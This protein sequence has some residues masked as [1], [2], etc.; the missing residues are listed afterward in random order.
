MATTIKK[1]QDEIEE[2]QLL[3]DDS[4]SDEMTKQLAKDEIASLKEQLKNMEMSDEDTDEDT[5]KPKGKRGRPKKDKSSVAVPKKKG[6]RGRPKKVV[7][8]KVVK[9]KKQVEPKE[10]GG[11]PDC[12]ELLKRWTERRAKAKTSNKKRKTKPV[13]RKIA[14]D[15]VDSVE[16]AIKNVPKTELKEKP[17]QILK[18]FDTLRA[19]AEQFLK[20]FR[21]VLG[22]DYK[23]SDAEKELKDL[24]VLIKGIQKK[25]S[26]KY[27]LGDM[28]E[29]RISSA[30]I[31]DYWQG[32]TINQQDHFLSDHSS[33]F[34]NSGSWLS[35]LGKPYENLPLDIQ[36]A[37][38]THLEEGRYGK[39]DMVDISEFNEGIVTDLY[40]K[41]N[42]KKIRT[43][44]QKS[45]KEAIESA[46]ENSK[47]YKGY[48]EVYI[49]AIF[50]GFSKNGHFKYSG[51]Y[52]GQ[53]Y[54]KGNTVKGGGIENSKEWKEYQVAS[55]N[56][57][58]FN[59]QNEFTMVDGKAVMN[60][61]TKMPE[62]KILNEKFKKSL[63]KVREMQKEGNNSYAKGDMVGGETSPRIYVAD[64]SAYNNGKL[65]GSWLDISDYSNGYEVMEA[66]GSLLEDWSEQ[67]GEVREEYAIHDFEGFPNELYSESMGEKEFDII[68]GGISI[69]EDKGVPMNVIVTIMKEY[70]LDADEVGDWFDEHYQGYFDNDEKF[71]DNYIDNIGGVEELGKDT[72]ATYFD[73]NSFGRD[74]AYDYSNYD[75]HYFSTYKKGGK[76]PKYNL[77]K[78]INK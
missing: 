20:A 67:S 1:I 73:Y 60:D 7:K 33:E 57:N 66:I 62:Y 3:L 36:M 2:Y 59:R 15:V 42:G 32:L 34:K 41:I 71:A 17:K 56:I 30:E 47:Y 51:R 61:V 69:S 11:E 76:V 55:N 10:D 68:I 70:S 6:K 54:A 29:G 28:V 19:S 50:V 72:L 48:A 52:K 74:L 24:E 21:G 5:D 65:I 23:T 16:K 40:D 13:F 58:R 44:N 31:R 77:T 4:S 37:I 64:L 38:Q 75:G 53:K 39:G 35:K 43:Q 22:D 25:Y 26:V 9:P 8:V 63:K 78:Y 27:G 14:S 12:D 18:K 49:G 45:L 46:N